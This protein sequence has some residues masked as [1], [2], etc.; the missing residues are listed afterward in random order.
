MVYVYFTTIFNK[1]KRNQGRK[2]ETSH[3]TMK[4]WKN[5]KFI[6]LSERSHSKRYILYDSNYM[7][8]WKMLNYKD[9][10]S[11]SSC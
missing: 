10:K 5:L 8:F 2:K 3:Q 7:T 1:R 6:F 11:S 4:T 9:N